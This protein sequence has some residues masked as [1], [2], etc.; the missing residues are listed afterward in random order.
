MPDLV[1]ERLWVMVNPCLQGGVPWQEHLMKQNLGSDSQV[2]IQI[3]EQI[4]I[5]IHIHLTIF[6]TP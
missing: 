6:W 4:H 2:Q 1:P 5:Q 3:Q